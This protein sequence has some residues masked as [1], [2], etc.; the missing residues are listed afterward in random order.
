MSYLS[1]LPRHHV[2][3]RVHVQ[4][5]ITHDTQASTR[6]TADDEQSAVIYS[7]ATTATIRSPTS[8]VQG[9]TRTSSVCLNKTCLTRTVTWEMLNGGM[10]FRT[11]SVKVAMIPFEVYLGEQDELSNGRSN[12]GVL[13][14][15][16]GF[17]QSWPMLVKRR[18]IPKQ[19]SRLIAL[20][21]RA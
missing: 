6:C 10:A 18:L 16:A 17:K 3:F 1:L 2:C 11:E 14:K 5:Q 12:R 19:K 9:T 4:R 21:T 15:K 13:V 20:R 7:N 8:A